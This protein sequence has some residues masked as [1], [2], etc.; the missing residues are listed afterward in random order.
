V[1]VWRDGYTGRGAELKGLEEILAD[2][3]LTVLTDYSSTDYYILNGQPMGYQYEMLQNLAE[4]LGVR[5][6]VS[7]SHDIGE[8]IE[9][10]QRGEAD[11]I[12]Q[13][14][15]IT[16]QR[17]QEVA[18]TIPFMIQGRYWCSVTVNMEVLWD[19]EELSAGLVTK[20][21]ATCRQR[22][23]CE[24][25]SASLIRLDNLS[26]EIGESI[27][28]VAGHQEQGGTSKGRFQW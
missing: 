3:K 21:P 19:S 9:M 26:E 16:A 12:A 27:H 15:I 25:G 28:I 18:F 7:I 6:E 24:K 20:P 5:L 4:Y 14:L 22:V 10:L 1:R 8:S 11:L 13:S 17:K 23:S 2:G